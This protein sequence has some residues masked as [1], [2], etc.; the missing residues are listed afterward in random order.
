MSKKLYLVIIK[1]KPLKIFSVALMHY[2]KLVL[3]LLVVYTSTV[4]LNKYIIIKL[5]EA[6]TI[7]IDELF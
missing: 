3:K 6:S 7:N 2:F 4:A 5:L 1:L